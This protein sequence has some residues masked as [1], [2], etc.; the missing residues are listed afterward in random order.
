MEYMTRQTQGRDRYSAISNMTIED[1]W[2]EYVDKKVPKTTAYIT[3]VAAQLRKEEKIE[4]YKKN[5][6]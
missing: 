5:L 2:K 3:R 1:F 4:N 6:R